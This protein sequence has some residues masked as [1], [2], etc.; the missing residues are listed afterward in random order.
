MFCN[1]QILS[2]KCPSEPSSEENEASLLTKENNHIFDCLQDSMK[3]QTRAIYEILHH[4]LE[5][6][7]FHRASNLKG[8]TKPL[9]NICPDNN[10]AEQQPIPN[11][12]PVR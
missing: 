2:Q 10:T 3:L 4:I 1:S 11:S 5:N 7:H 9:N 6:H 12:A 8:N